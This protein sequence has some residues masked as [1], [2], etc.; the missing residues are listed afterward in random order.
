MSR[1]FL[2]KRRVA[3]RYDSVPRTIDRWVKN[4]KLPTPIYHGKTPLW[5]QDELDAHDRKATVE[6][7]TITESAEVSA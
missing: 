5:D 6:R 2:R 7:A 1:T 3:Q 4:G